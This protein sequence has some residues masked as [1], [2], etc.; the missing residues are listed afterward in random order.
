MRDW[1][2]S[3]V[4]FPGSPTFTD[5]TVSAEGPEPAL[6]GLEVLLLISFFFPS[7]FRFFFLFF[8]MFCFFSFCFSFFFCFLLCYV[9]FCFVLFFLFFCFHLFPLS[10]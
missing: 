5:S 3:A 4:G 6:S 9:M 10:L 7:V 1:T 2:N 8:V